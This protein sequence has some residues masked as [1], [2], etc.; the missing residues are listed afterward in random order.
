MKIKGILVVFLI[1]ICSIFN[2]VNAEYTGEGL[3]EIYI[4]GNDN[5]DIVESYNK[6]N[7]TYEGI[8]PKLYSKIE[9]IAG[10]N[11]EYKKSHISKGEEIRNKQ[12]ELVTLINEESYPEVVEKIKVFVLEDGREIFIG[13]TSLADT[14]LINKIKGTVENLTHEEREYILL[15]TL[16]DELNAIKYRRDYYTIFA[17]LV[18]VSLVLCMYVRH[19]RKKIRKEKF[20]DK[21]T[22]YSN[23]NNF[24]EKYASFVGKIA[25]QNYCLID[26]GIN[27]SNIEEVYGYDEVEKVLKEI[28]DILDQNMNDNE[29]F[30]RRTESSMLL[31]LNY[32]SE[33][34]LEERLVMLVEKI[35]NSIKKYNFDIAC[36]IYFLK[37]SDS[38]LD[39]PILYALSARKNSEKN[40]K[41]ITF[42]T[43]KVASNID[44]NI[45]LEKN[46]LE[47]IRRHKFI[48]YAQPIIDINDNTVFAI[49]ILARWENEKYGLIK[50]KQFLNI[51]EKNNM[52]YNLDMQM[53]RN[54]C[55]LLQKF[56]NDGH[57]NNLKVF[58]NFARN[59]FSREDFLDSLKE[60]LEEYRIEANMIGIIIT[61]DTLRNRTYNIK[62]CVKALKEEGFC[63]ILD[64]F[65][66]SRDSLNDVVHLNC[67]YIKFS[68]KLLENITTDRKKKIIMQIIKLMKEFN[69]QVICENVENDKMLQELKCMKFSY[70]QGN[71]Y[72][73]AIPVEELINNKK[74]F[75]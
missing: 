58:C 28:A 38:D 11:L 50:P 1:L 24:L 29:M 20:T 72:C 39:K 33:Q 45:F 31:L 30:C 14:E 65:G 40:G 42:C 52:L 23:Y 61:E 35:K 74:I 4:L 46:I 16:N 53:F 68:P 59:A 41:L 37:T 32:V 63:V 62:T 60:I 25:R 64:N 67:D 49:E 44:K 3:S 17:I 18:F 15:S 9:E 5:L 36:G 56:K 6:K 12:V 21:I 19:L 73:Q 75:F 48:S 26:L 10:L 43:R 22:L 27:L 71:F 70:L 47:D 55:E 51:L 66:G 7:G 57:N 34:Y 13:F 8:M 54:A 69:T 2:S